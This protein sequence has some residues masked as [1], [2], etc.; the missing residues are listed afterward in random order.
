MKK[1][2]II[3]FSS[4]GDIVLTSPI[5]R[6]LKEQLQDSEIHYLT[7]K[8]FLPILKENPFIHKIHTIE[9]KIDEIISELKSEDFDHIVDLHKNIR[10]RSVIFKLKRPNSSY[11]KL[12]LQ[13]YILV[14][15]K[16]NLLPDIHIVDRYFKAVEDLGVANDNRGLDYFISDDLKAVEI[17]QT[18]QKDFIGFVIGGKHNTKIMPE[19]KVISVCNKTKKPI[20]L[21]GG[22]EDI[23]KGERI[24]ESTGDNVYNACGKYSLSQSAF[25]I[26]R[27]AK[28]FT[29]DTGLMHIAAAFKKEIVSVWGNT[30][31]AFGMYPYLPKGEREKS[32][33][34]EVKGLRCRPCT[35]IGYQKCPKGH[36]KCMVDIDEE[37]LVS[38]ILKDKRQ[39]DIKS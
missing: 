31:P 10:S 28:I 38:E 6:C 16:I 3:R 22:K 17:P 21:L 11:R 8:Q 32:T 13:K 34:M 9:S 29:N 26:S 2:L 1:I 30:V 5:I 39:Q 14:N 24:Q 37:L 19:E 20:V 18:H 15:F 27:A 12:N 4:I 36:F 23:E 7:K 25:L 35:K 33:I